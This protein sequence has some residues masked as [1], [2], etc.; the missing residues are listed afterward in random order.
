MRKKIVLAWLALLFLGIVT[1]FWYNEWKYSL[2]TPV[3]E[4]YQ[5]VATGTVIKAA[6][7]MVQNKQPLFLHF[8][9]PDCPCSRFNTTYFKKLVKKYEHVARFVI[10]PMS[11]KPITAEEIRSRFDLSLPVIFDTSLAR[12]CGVYST[13]QA[14]IIDTSYHLYYRGNYNKSRYCTDT[15]SN[16]A[17]I[18]LEALLNQRPH[19]QFDK[20]ALQAYGCQ[21]PTCTQ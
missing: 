16:Y 2:P 15:Q 11:K 6:Q 1:L 21:L 20:Y 5:A 13:P 9:N 7:P 17:E 4:S 12:T 19:V 18:A 10:V 14:V 8:F 3:P